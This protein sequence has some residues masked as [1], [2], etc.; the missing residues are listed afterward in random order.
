MKLENI[1]VTKDFT[2]KLADFGLAVDISD[3]PYIKSQSGTPDY[4]PPEIHIG[5]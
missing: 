1:V 2:L 5:R 4:W 3:Q